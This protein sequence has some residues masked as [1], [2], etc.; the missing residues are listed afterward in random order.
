MTHIQQTEKLA[1]R[2][3]D[4]IVE[5]VEHTDGPVPLGQLN[6]DIPDFASEEPDAWEY[7]LERNDGE[8]IIWTN[9]TEAGVVGL[10]KAISERRIAIQVLAN[11]LP[12]VIAWPYPQCENWLPVVLLPAK[13]AN[14]DTPK[15]LMRASAAYQKHRMEE[16]AVSGELGYRLLTP[17]P[18]RCTADQFSV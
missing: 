4:A 2:I 16:T 15:W 12:Y 5:L 11:P 1:R 9:M 7:Y 8:T 13:A 3:A 6:R 14:L 18:V 17:G 10:R